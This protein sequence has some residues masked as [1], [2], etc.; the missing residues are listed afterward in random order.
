MVLFSLV[1][2]VMEYEYEAAME[3]HYRSS[4]LKAFRKTVNDGYFPFIIVDCVNHQVKHFE[5][6][7]SYAKQK[8][9]QVCHK[10]FWFY[11][12]CS[13]SSQIEGLEQQ[14]IGHVRCCLTDLAN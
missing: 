9:F 10:V 13:E 3:K 5:E 1:Q 6:M 11:E 2:Q 7:W 4:L 14:R 8:G 12:A